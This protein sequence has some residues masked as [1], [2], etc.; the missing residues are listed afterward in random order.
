MGINERRGG[1]KKIIL[2]MV[3]LILPVS[4]QAA[5]WGN[6][7]YIVVPPAPGYHIPNVQMQPIQPLISP[8]DAGTELNRLT[9]NQLMMEQARMLQMQRQ[10]MYQQQQ[11]QQ[12]AQLNMLVQKFLVDQG[13]NPGPIDGVWGPRSAQALQEY[14]AKQNA[15]GK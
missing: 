9:Q 15:A 14:T 5:G 6:N 12:Q 7:Y 11:T 2:I 3:L 8:F 4:A 13:Y 1:M 10:Q